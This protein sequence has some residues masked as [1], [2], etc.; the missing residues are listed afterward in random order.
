[1]RA[2]PVIEGLGPFFHVTDSEKW[3][4]I[5]SSRLDPNRQETPPWGELPLSG[6]VVFLC[7]RKEVRGIHEMVKTRLWQDG[8]S[9]LKVVVLEV[10]SEFLKTCEVEHDPTYHQYE[11][12]RL[13]EEGLR[14]YVREHGVMACLTPIPAWALRVVDL[15]DPC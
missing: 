14:S 6:K 13:S 15:E 3:E 10:C 9:D 5:R 1:M 4:S 8:R 11:G 7:S 12:S 2:E